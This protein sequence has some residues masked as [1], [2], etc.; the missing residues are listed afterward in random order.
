MTD[1]EIQLMRDQIKTEVE[2]DPMDGGIIVP[3]GGDGIQR[4]PVGPDMM[5]IDPKMPADD[6]A[7]A[8]LGLDPAQ[9]SVTP[10]A[11]A[12]PEGAAGSAADTPNPSG[13]EIDRSFIVKNGLKGRKK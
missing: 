5:P 12:P 7:K 13:E 3:P 9:P 2:T 1:S 4:I 10:T 6:R 8:A 11:K